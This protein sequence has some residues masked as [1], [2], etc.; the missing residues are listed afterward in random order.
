MGAW[1]AS[2]VLMADS[3]AA[4][5]F[6]APALLAA[7][8]PEPEDAF[9]GDVDELLE[10]EPHPTTTTAHTSAASMNLALTSSL[11]LVVPQQV[12]IPGVAPFAAT[13]RAA[14]RRY[15]RFC[16]A[17]AQCIEPSYMLQVPRHLSG[18]G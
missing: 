4:S 15:V 7:A 12:A 17:Y 5:A 2:N 13:A 6:A 16:A 14:A 9:V 1:V 3:A 11:L 10:V 8:V 18:R